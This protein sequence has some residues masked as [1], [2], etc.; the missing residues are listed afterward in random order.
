MLA[1][2]AIGPSNAQYRKELEYLYARRTAVDA[3]IESLQEY[4]RFRPKT[5]EFDPQRRP[6][7]FRGFPEVSGQFRFGRSA[8]VIPANDSGAVDQDQGR[9]CAGAISQEVRGAERRRHI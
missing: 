8:R 9:G 4:E 7:L 5:I 2:K 3:L 1:K 6:T